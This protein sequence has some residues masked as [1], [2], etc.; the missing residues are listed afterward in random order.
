MRCL[1]L[2]LPV[3]ACGVESVGPTARDRARAEALTEEAVT[4]AE[5]GANLDAVS[6]LSD[7]LDSDP[8]NERAHR[9]RA[10]LGERVSHFSEVIESSEWLLARYPG[11]AGNVDL[12]SS[13]VRSALNDGLV[14][15]AESA[16][17]RLERM[18][19]NSG[20]TATLWA[21]LHL[22]NGDMARAKRSARSAVKL[23]PIQTVGH[24]I[25]GLALED[26]GDMEE[27]ILSFRRVL[28]VDPGHLGARD[29]LA[30]LLLRTDRKKEAGKHRGIHTALTR[31]MPGGFR[32]FRATDRVTTFTELVELLPDWTT[33]HMELARALSQAGRLDDARA[34]AEVGLALDRRN[35]ELNELM[36][37]ILRGLGDDAGARKHAARSRL[38]GEK[39]RR[40][41]KAE[42]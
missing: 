15:V 31:A 19:P 42:Q 1:L 38:P 36:A 24:H 28:K 3:L 27:A 34:R 39:P 7:A 26:E 29:H 37:T 30:T 22:E 18:E 17:T 21:R 25:L 5:N 41:R 33:G 6:M 40:D 23:V 14:D 13:I 32:Q 4:V 35:P 20:R 16:L 12:L 11:D 8:E 2:V 9:M 10:V